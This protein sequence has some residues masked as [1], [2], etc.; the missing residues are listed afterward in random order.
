MATVKQRFHKYTVNGQTYYGAAPDYNLPYGSQWVDNL[1]EVQQELPKWQAKTDEWS[2]NY[3]RALQ[4][5][6]SDV[7]A[8]ITPYA[9][10]PKGVLTTQKALSEQQAN[11]AAVA[12]GTMERWGTAN[13]PLYVPKGTLTPQQSNQAFQAGQPKS[14]Y[15]EV[16]NQRAEQTGQTLGYTGPSIVDYLKSVNQASDYGSRSKLAEQYGIK[17]YTGTAEQNT[18]LL[19]ILRNQGR[20][21]TGT[22][23]IG[24][25]GA[26]GEVLGAGAGS[27]ATGG[28]NADESLKEQLMGGIG[29]QGGQQGETYEQAFERMK[30]EKGIGGFESKISSFDDEIR[31]ANDLLSEMTTSLRSG[32]AKESDR[33][34]PMELLVGRSQSLENQA[35]VRRQD[36][37]G[38]LSSLETGRGQA[39][40]EVERRNQDILQALQ[41]RQ[42]QEQSQRQQIGSQLDILKTLQGLQPKADYENYIETSEGIYD[43]INKTWVERFNKGGTGGG[44]LTPAQINTTVNSIAGAFDNEPIVKSYNTA[45]EG[46]QTI[47][48]I[49]TKTSSPADDIAFIYAFAK[50]MD[51]NS[52]VREGE[53]NTIQRYAQTW[54]DNFGFKAQRLF[55]N[56]NFLSADAKQKMLNALAPKIKTLETQY[57]NLESEYQ[58]QIQ[59]AYSGKPRQIT[60][61]S[62]FSGE[63]DGDNLSDEDAWALYLQTQQ[64]GGG[65][66]IFNNPNPYQ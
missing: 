57:K 60:N 56:T 30:G 51:P 9:L 64:Q 10:D 50:I 2:Q 14:V 42:Q 49:G 66:N 4:K 19:N 5:G 59:D 52:V 7:Q 11:E 58:R 18:N 48:S 61:Y 13:A 44:G 6:L 1:S 38:A 25:T 22:A 45:Q 53:Y 33:L 23:P 12:A 54:A 24:A 40:S 34:G 47:K 35:G 29:G 8:G 26:I 39:L 16:V 17:E 20:G 21:S 41:L 62:A 32:L 28:K 15:Q 55:S 37:L 3:V 27:G 36:V 63:G 46:Y 31:K 65:V 43:P